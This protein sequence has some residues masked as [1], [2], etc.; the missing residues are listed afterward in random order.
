MNQRRKKGQFVA[1][2]K[3]VPRSAPSDNLLPGEEPDIRK[4]IASVVQDPDGWLSQPNDQ[5]GGQK[6][7]DLI[8]TERE[9]SVRDLLRAIKHGMLA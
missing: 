5:L 2:K 7:G 8:G 3:P 4:D 6:P 9:Q 1:R